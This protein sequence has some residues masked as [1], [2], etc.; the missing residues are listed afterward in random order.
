MKVRSL[1]LLLLAPLATFAQVGIGTIDPLTTLEVAGVPADNDVADG[2]TIPS[3]TGDELRAKNINGKYTAL[4]EGTIVYVTAAVTIPAALELT[5]NVTSSGFFYFDG[6]TWQRVAVSTNQ[7]HKE[8]YN[9]EYAG[10]VLQADGT[11]NSLVLN[12][13]NSGAPDF[14]NYYEASNFNIDGGTNDFN[15]TLRITLPQ[16]FNSWSASTDAIVI[17]FEGTTDASFE[18]DVFEEG[19]ATPVQDNVAVSGTGLTGFVEN[20]LG[21]NTQ[22][23]ALVAGDTLIIVVK[24]SVTDV[25]TQNDSVIRIG[26][27]TLNYNKVQ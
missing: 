16:D 15:V 2:I 24:L 11:D 20:T 27:I 9:A 3:M 26:D 13:T 5:E 8:V 25:V 23:N 12:A 22:L 14:L 21:T 7:E 6:A 10:A 19:N 18:A 17:D 1:I 4:Y